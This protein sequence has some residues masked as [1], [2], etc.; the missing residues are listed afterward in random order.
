MLSENMPTRLGGFQEEKEMIFRLVSRPVQP[1][2]ADRVCYNIK[3]L[4]NILA[5]FW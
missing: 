2:I 1:E 3:A 5:N 4:N